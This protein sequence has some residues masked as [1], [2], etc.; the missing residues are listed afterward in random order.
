MNSIALRKLFIP[1]GEVEKITDS[2][3]ILIWKKPHIYG[4]TWAG[5]TTPTMSRTDDAANFSSPVIGVGTTAGS[6]PFD[7][8]YPWSKMEAINDGTNALVL[9]PKYWYKWT[10]SGSAMTLQI[11]DRPVEG[12]S[13]SPMHADRGDGKGERDVAYIGRYKC[14]SSYTSVSGKAPISNITIATARSK[15]KEL[16]TGFYQQD[17]ASFWTIRML[18]LVEFATWDSQSI[19]QNTTDFSTQSDIRTGK[20]YGMAYHTGISADGYS[21]KYRHIEDPWENTLEWVDGIYFNGTNTY[22]INN[23]NNFATGSNGTW[24]GTRTTSTGYIS[25]WTIPTTAGYGWALIPA[26]AATAESYTYDG[27]YYTSTGTI[28]YIGGARAAWEVHGAFF[29]YSDFTANSTS[30]LISTRLMYLP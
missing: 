1:E 9:I 8:C 2:S 14:C 6:S 21:V 26:S 7:S 30:S 10:K 13:V 12:F 20:T 22:I 28:L 4:V 23:P 15:I 5:G 19:L 16:G 29:M 25:S 24:I 27:Y 11:A 3:G 18:F 17:Y